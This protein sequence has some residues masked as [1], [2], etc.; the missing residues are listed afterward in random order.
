M[1]WC[2][3]DFEVITF[4]STC[5]TNEFVVSSVHT[6]SYRYVWIRTIL[7]ANDFVLILPLL[8]LMFILSWNCSVV[9]QAWDWLLL[10]CSWIWQWIICLFQGTSGRWQSCSSS[11]WRCSSWKNK[12]FESGFWITWWSQNDGHVV[13]SNQ[14]HEQICCNVSG[15]LVHRLH[16]W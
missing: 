15:G 7:R 1:F 4:V 13:P 10:C 8:C 5:L 14:R 9:F 11:M 6:N 16:C 12:R 3:K 2:R